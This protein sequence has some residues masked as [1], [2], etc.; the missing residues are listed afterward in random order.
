MKKL[1]IIGV[2]GGFELYLYNRQKQNLG[3]LSNSLTFNP[4]VIRIDTNESC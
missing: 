4:S 1:L 3:E 2:F